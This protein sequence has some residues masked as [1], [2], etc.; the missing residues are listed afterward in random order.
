MTTIAAAAAAATVA[1][2]LVDSGRAWMFVQKCNLSQRCRCRCC[3]EMKICHSAASWYIVEKYYCRAEDFSLC[4]RQCK[5]ASLHVARSHTTQ[6]SPLR[7]KLRRVNY[8]IELWRTQNYNFVHKIWNMGG[9][10]RFATTPQGYLHI[11]VNFALARM[12]ELNLAGPTW[13]WYSASSSSDAFDIRK[14]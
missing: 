11:T 10:W 9:G 12:A 7:R 2:I 6:R 5:L 1:A 4:H 13:H 8:L 14:L 3:S